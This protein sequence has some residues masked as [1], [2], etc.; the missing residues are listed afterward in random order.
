ML[1]LLRIH[2]NVFSIIL[3]RLTKHVHNKLDTAV[4][5]FWVEHCAGHKDKESLYSSSLF[6]ITLNLPQN[7]VA[8]Y[9]LG[10]FFNFASNKKLQIRHAFLSCLV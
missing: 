9:Y 5:I 6:V 3:P 7:Q 10:H 8:R 4:S 1:T 2:F